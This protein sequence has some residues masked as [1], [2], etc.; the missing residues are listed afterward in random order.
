MQL[1]DDLPPAQLHSRSQRHPDPVQQ[2]DRPRQAARH[3]SQGSAG[4]RVRLAVTVQCPPE[5][6]QR[7][8]VCP[9]LEA[10]DI[11]LQSESALQEVVQIPLP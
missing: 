8:L 2:P 1:P 4:V 7:S 6:R 3:W 11:P 5:Q 10:S 9:K